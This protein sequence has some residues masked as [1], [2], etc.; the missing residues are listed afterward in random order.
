MHRAERSTRYGAHVLGG[1]DAVDGSSRL[2]YPMS[3][4][5]I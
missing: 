3:T 4:K 1:I 5:I 2:Y